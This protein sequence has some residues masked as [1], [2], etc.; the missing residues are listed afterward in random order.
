MCLHSV[1]CVNAAALS[2]IRGLAVRRPCSVF[3]GLSLGDELLGDRPWGDFQFLRNRQ[4]CPRRPCRL[5]CRVGGFR[6]PPGV[7][8][9]LTVCCLK[10]QP[11]RRLW[12]GFVVLMCISRPLAVS[13]SGATGRLNVPW[14]K[15]VSR[16]FACFNWDVCR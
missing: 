12:A 8:A 5:P 7:P 4:T 9:R 6:D 3:V 11:F 2:S 13:I 1:G 14:E 16:A 10:L 15:R